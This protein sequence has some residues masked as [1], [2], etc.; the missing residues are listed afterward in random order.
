MDAT[1]S[2]DRK[3]KYFLWGTVLTW[4]LS[5]PLMVGMFNSFRGIQPEKATGLAAV[6]GGISEAYTTLGLILA[7]VLPV[8]AIVLLV[9][10]F[11]GEHRMRALFSVLYIGWSAITLLLAGLFVW[12]FF[13]HMPHTASGPR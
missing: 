4:T 9:R 1:S 7:F 13:I 11:S 5:I 8:G 3:K 6:A 2:A 12:V 10:S